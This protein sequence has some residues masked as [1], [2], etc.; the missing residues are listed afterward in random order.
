MHASAKQ[1]NRANNNFVQH[2]AVAGVQLGA[3][4]HSS[5]TLPAAGTGLLATAR[6]HAPQSHELGTVRPAR[7]AHMIRL[8][9]MNGA[10]LAFSYGLN[11]PAR[12]RRTH[13]DPPARS[14]PWQAKLVF[15]R[16]VKA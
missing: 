8:W 5:H 12:Q 1:I 10:Y 16:Q 13:S 15:T 9:L 6:L 4:R 11:R 3:P 14:P 2:R 7:A